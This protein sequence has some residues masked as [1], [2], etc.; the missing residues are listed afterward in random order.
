MDQRASD[1]R[2]GSPPKPYH[3]LNA[4][5]AMEA[6]AAPSRFQQWVSRS[7]LHKTKA[8]PKQQSPRRTR[9]PT[10]PRPQQKPQWNGS[11]LL[12]QPDPPRKP[13]PPRVTPPR[14]TRAMQPDSATRAKRPRKPYNTKRTTSSRTSS[15][16]PSRATTPRRSPEQYNIPTVPRAP[17]P[18][19]GVGDQSCSVETHRVCDWRQHC[20]PIG[21][22][23]QNQRA[24]PGLDISGDFTSRLHHHYTNSHEPQLGCEQAGGIAGEWPRPLEEIA[25]ALERLEMTR[26]SPDRHAPSPGCGDMLRAF[27]ATEFSQICRCCDRRFGA[28]EVVMS[29]PAC[30]FDVCCSCFE[31]PPATIDPPLSQLVTLAARDSGCLS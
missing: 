14:P 11:T 29:C 3:S 27:S 22:V 6:V 30:D 7:K 13:S 15:R 8:T 10:S 26:Q 21:L 18:H 23:M 31:M 1:L 24:P 2:H 19:A 20:T 17:V 4:V 9:P 5:A 16:S 28:G 25:A 12:S